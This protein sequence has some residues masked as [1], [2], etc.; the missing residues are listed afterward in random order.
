[1][2]RPKSKKFRDQLP[3]PA[4]VRIGKI[5]EAFLAMDIVCTGTLSRRTKLCGKPA[6]ICSR[7]PA[8]RHGPYFEWG[9][10]KGGRLVGRMVSPQSA[11]VIRK[12]IANYKAARRL[13][14]AWEN[15]TEALIET[16]E[17][18]K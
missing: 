2:S 4:R 3:E 16:I 11:R 1:M 5:Q 17:R 10:M 6:C 9:R 14:R 13:L 7:D 8:A 12:G 18:R 15:Q